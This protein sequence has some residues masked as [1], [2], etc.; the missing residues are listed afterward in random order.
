MDNINLPLMIYNKYVFIYCIDGCKY[1]V[2]NVKTK[3]TFIYDTYQDAIDSLQ[4][5]YQNY[6]Q[7]A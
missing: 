7:P 5:L 4:S 1:K 3:E 6:S 2:E